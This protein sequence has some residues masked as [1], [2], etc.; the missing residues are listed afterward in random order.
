MVE[1]V[2]AEIARW[3]VVADGG[4]WRVMAGCSAD[5]ILH[6]T[7]HTA[8]EAMGEMRARAVIKAMRD[9][10]DSMVFRCVP[11]FDWPVLEPYERM[12]DAALMPDL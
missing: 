2:A 11:K 4:G 10:S 3:T 1:R 8:R 6:P 5:G 9:P 7:E 12:I